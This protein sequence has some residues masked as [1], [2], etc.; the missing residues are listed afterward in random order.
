MTA[1]ENTNI[2]SY[3]DFDKISEDAI[4]AMQFVASTKVVIGKT[5]T[6]L[7]PKDTLTRAEFAEMIYR[8]LG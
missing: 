4:P 8:F 1:G 5:S 2:L 6:T 3:E 7:N